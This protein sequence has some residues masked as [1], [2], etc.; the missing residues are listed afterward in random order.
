MTKCVK[1]VSRI[2]NYAVY[3]YFVTMFVN[4]YLKYLYT[5]MLVSH[6]VSCTNI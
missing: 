1:K 2:Y 3:F 4:M 5:V 6:L